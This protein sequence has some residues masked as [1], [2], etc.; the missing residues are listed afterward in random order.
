M[1]APHHELENPESLVWD[2]P[3]PTESLDWQTQPQALEQWVDQEQPAQAWEQEALTQEPVADEPV[4]QVAAEPSRMTR[5]RKKM[6]EPLFIRRTIGVALI[7]A[8]AFGVFHIVFQ[9]DL[10]NP[11]WAQAQPVADFIDWVKDDPRRAWV[12]AAGLVI[13]HIGLYYMLFDDNSR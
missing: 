11:L 5:M 8:F 4:D 1:S 10:L 6:R 9:T 12:A 2:Q 7:S 3:A 13:P